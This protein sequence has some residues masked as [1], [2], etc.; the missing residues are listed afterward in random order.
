M[1]Q[2]LNANALVDA[3]H[4]A[5]GVDAFDCDSY[6]EG[7]DVF[8]EDFNDGIAKGLY[9]DQGIERVRAD[10]LKYL[11]D[12]LKVWGYLQQNPELLERPIERPVFRARRAAHR[13]HA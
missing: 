10:C 7:L 5:T 3:A 1:A 4:K 13:H 12:R 11:S 2:P 9:N 8:V 6:R